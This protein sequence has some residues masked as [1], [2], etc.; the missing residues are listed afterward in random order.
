MQVGIC[1]YQPLKR[2]GKRFTAESIEKMLQPGMELN[3]SY[4]VYHVCI[5]YLLELWPRGT[6]IFLS[7]NKDKI[8]QIVSH[9]GIIRGCA[10]IKFYTHVHTTTYIFNITFLLTINDSSYNS[11]NCLQLS[12]TWESYKAIWMLDIGGHLELW[13]KDVD[14]H[15]TFAAV[16]NI[17]LGTF[18]KL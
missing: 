11:F 15:N 2:L 3:Y 6:I 7:K 13:V 9:C 17:L 1:W 4:F 8:L 14:N 12:N 5:P 10:T 16:V 18:W